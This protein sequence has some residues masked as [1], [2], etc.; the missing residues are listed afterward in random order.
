MKS[1]RLARGLLGTSL[2]GVPLIGLLLIAG[3]SR[4]V[5]RADNANRKESSAESAALAE[6]RNGSVLKLLYSRIPMTLNPHLATG[7]QDFEAARI[8]YE[9]LATYE[10]NGDLI[11]VLAALIP[12]PENGGIAADGRSV[13]WKLKP[14]IRWSDGQPFTADDVVFTYQFVSDP[15][16]AAST[17]KYYEAVEKV[18]ALDP[19][20]VKITFKSPNP[21]WSLPFTGQN[22]MIIPKH[23]FAASKGINARQAPANLQPVGTGPFRFITI[24]DGLWT[25]SAN[26]QYRDGL[27]GFSL[28]ELEGGVAPYVAAR[29]VLRDST[30]DFAHNLQLSI[31]DRVL[32]SSAGKGRVVATFGSY[33]ERLMLNPTDPKKVTETGERSS[34]DNP[35]PFLSDVVVRRAIDHAI[36]RDAIATQIYGNAGQRTNQLLPF[37]EEYANPNL[38]HRYDPDFAGRLLDDAGWVDTNENGIR[39]KDGTEM[40]IVFQTPI[41]PVRQQTQALIK[42]DLEKIGIDVDIRRVIVDDFFSADPTQTRSINHFYADMQEYN[43]GSDTP[44]PSIYMSWWLCSEIA[45]QKNQW[46]KPNNARYC[47]PEYDKTWKKANEELNPEARAQL[48]QRLNTILMQDYAVIPLVRRAVTNGL[49]SRLTGVDPTPWDASTWDIGTWEPFK[50]PEEKAAEE[51]EKA[52]QLEAESASED[53]ANESP[54]KDG[55]AEEEPSDRNAPQNIPPDTVTDSPDAVPEETASPTESKDE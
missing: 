28:V 48:F 51:A 35:H 5:P 11:P 53:S 7:F 52:L 37:P 49:S 12:T 16:V 30:A 34:V 29:R 18:E 41:N 45:S 50:T 36:S 19:L 32:L 2:V 9:P 27:P 1:F 23:I 17:A 21:S 26:E 24:N 31:E 42:A 44:D 38:Y 33:V 43:A 14:D 47:N 39:D 25:F 54:N 15:N 22:G 13:T 46:Q 4:L 3:C 8:V 6:A 40:R 20:T 10:P 55:V